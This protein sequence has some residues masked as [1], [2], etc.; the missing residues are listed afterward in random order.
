LILLLKSFPKES[1]KM[2][3]NLLQ[4]ND[5]LR[6]ALLRS[7]PR[8]SKK[9]GTYSGDEGETTRIKLFNTGL[10]T[11]I[12]LYVT[13]LYTV[14]THVTAATDF[15]PYNFIKRIKLVD[16]DGTTRVDCSGFQ[17][18]QVN[19]RRYKTPYGL[20]AEGLTAVS[21]APSAP[22][23]ATTDTSLHWVEIP[24]A[25]DPERDLRGAMLAQTTVGEMQL[26]IE[27]ATTF[28]NATQ[29][30]DYPFYVSSSSTVGTT[31]T[32]VEVYQDYLQPVALGN[33]VPIPPIDVMTVYE[34]S[35]LRSSDNLA[36]NAE[37]LFNFPNQRAVIAAHLQYVADGA[38]SGSITGFRLLANG[39][40]TI[41]EM[42]L[43]RQLQNQRLMLH[44][45]LVAGAYIF[46]YSAK[47]IQTAQYG[48]VQLGMT[49]SA[50]GSSS[51]YADI[52]WECLYAKGQSLAGFAQTA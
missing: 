23:T 52:T 43:A 14:G 36:A 1:T 20:N 25:I 18:W 38:N 3:D 46:D 10:L 48:N 15:A 9:I 11:R 21:A 29:N 26:V 16:F 37:K 30:M 22:V 17:L 34:I 19:S 50:I 45:D 6:V 31:S 44:S 33:V 2:A 12:R 28:Q 49:P 27:W 35:S 8:M 42:T 4:Q 13:A 39:S 47:P 7:S 40:Q 5:A 51:Q 32:S 24:L 41:E